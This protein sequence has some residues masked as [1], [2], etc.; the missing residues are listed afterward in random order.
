MYVRVLSEIYD[1]IAVELAGVIP[2]ARLDYLRRTI[3]QSLAFEAGDISEEAIDLLHIEAT[4]NTGKLEILVQGIMT[5]NQLGLEDLVGV[6]D[7]NLKNLRDLADVSARTTDIVRN[8][9]AAKTKCNEALSWVRAICVR[10]ENETLA[11]SC[12][13][14]IEAANEASSK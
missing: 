12:L 2:A 4:Q 13:D 7:D 1:L 3:D 10:M 6:T 8:T 9:E 5:C 14:L 11:E